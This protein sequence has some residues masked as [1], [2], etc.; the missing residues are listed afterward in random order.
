MPT[1]KSIAFVTNTSW[2][3]YKFR[4]YLIETLISKG[5]TIYVL[6]PRDRYTAQFS[7]LP[8]LTYIELKKFKGKSIS[9][10][11]DLA[12]YRE[13]HRHYSR[14]KPDL[15]FHYTVKANLFGSLAAA[16]ARRLAVSVVTGL[17]YTFSRKGWLQ[18]AVRILYKRAFRKC[19]E[20]WFL[21]DDD[22]HFFTEQRLVD[23]ARTFVLPGEGVDTDAFFPAPF[24]PG[25]AAVTFLLIGRIIR[26]KGIREFVRAAELL[27]QQGLTVQCQLLGF[28]DENNPVAIPL[29]Q[30]QEWES[31]RILTYLGHTDQ[32]S[33]FIEQADCIVLP[34]Y[35]EGMPLSLLEGASM[36]K[37]LIATDTPGCR[38]LIEEGVNGY[39]CRVRDDADLAKKMAAY[40]HLPAVAKR[41]MGI[42]ARSKV[43]KEFTRE[44]IARIYQEKIESIAAPVSNIEY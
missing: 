16:R 25:K 28:F 27:R 13:L 37:A 11:H 8:G 31:R 32:V 3:I 4:L 24:E 2:S 14:I 36:C 42:E 18:S 17:G 34:S 5:Y 22:L 9:P 15:I 43:L 19:A 21:N 35:R 44:R 6:A 20:V 29:R 12:L 7:D 30:V 39:L 41:Q 1:K 10:L 40:Y 33:S 23:P 26:H 38:T